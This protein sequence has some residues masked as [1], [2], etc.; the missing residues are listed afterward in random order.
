MEYKI[1]SKNITSTTLD[2]TIADWQPWQGGLYSC[3]LINNFNEDDICS[4]GWTSSL[5][6]NDDYKLYVILRILGGSAECGMAAGT[7]FTSPLSIN[8]Y[9]GFD[10]VSALSCT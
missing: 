3:D 1:V 2:A 10:I 9:S 7:Q 6:P 5:N 4:S 8:I